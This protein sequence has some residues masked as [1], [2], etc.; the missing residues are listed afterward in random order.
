MS[1][2]TQGSILVEEWMY[3]QLKEESEKDGCD[4]FIETIYHR[5]P[6]PCRT[7][8]LVRLKIY[9]SEQTASVA[10]KNGRGPCYF[11][12]KNGQIYYPRAG[13]IEYLQKSRYQGEKL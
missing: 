8:D 12:P 6:D 10:R 9:S 4:E 2:A 11:K 1:E 7:K 5:L 13:V 3:K